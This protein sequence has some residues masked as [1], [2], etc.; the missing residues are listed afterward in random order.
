MT[1][2]LKSTLM[3]VPEF[4]IGEMPDYGKLTRSFELVRIALNTLER[5]IGDVSGFYP[6]NTQWSESPLTNLCL[7][8]H[9]GPISTIQ[10]YCAVDENIEA[11][12]S[13][14]AGRNEWPLHLWPYDTSGGVAYTM[15]ATAYDVDGNLLFQNDVGVG[16]TLEELGDYKYDSGRNMIRSFQ[17]MVSGTARI[18]YT[19]HLGA[20]HKLGIGNFWD[21]A[22]AGLNVMPSFYVP[23]HLCTSIDVSASPDPTYDYLIIMKPEQY[24]EWSP[25]LDQDRTRKAS[26]T[27]P[28]VFDQERGIVR[29]IT[30]TS[31][32]AQ[33]LPSC[34]TS[35]SLGD[36][37]PSSLVALYYSAAHGTGVINAGHYFYKDQTSFYYKKG[38][39]LDPTTETYRVIT[40]AGQDMDTKIEGMAFTLKNHRHRGPQAISHRDLLHQGYS[41]ALSTLPV[42]VQSDSSL[43]WHRPTNQTPNLDNPHPQYLMRNGYDYGLDD[44]NLNNLMLGDLGFSLQTL[45]IKTAKSTNVYGLDA[46]AYGSFGVDFGG[47]ADIRLITYEP[48]HRPPYLSIRTVESLVTRVGTSLGLQVGRFTNGALTGSALAVNVS[49]TSKII[50]VRVTGATS[51][52]VINDCEIDKLYVTG[53]NHYCALTENH[54]GDIS[55][56]GYGGSS[57]YQDNILIQQNGFIAGNSYNE[58]INSTALSNQIVAIHSTVTMNANGSC[59]IGAMAVAGE[60]NILECSNIK[61]D[62]CAI[63]STVTVDGIQNASVE[64]LSTGGTFNFDRYDIAE[65]M[66]YKYAQDGFRFEAQ[67]WLHRK[68]ITPNYAYEMIST[69]LAGPETN[70]F[71]QM[72]SGDSTG[73][74]RIMAIDRRPGRPTVD[75]DLYPSTRFSYIQSLADARNETEVARGLMIDFDLDSDCHIQNVHLCLRIDNTQPADT[76]ITVESYHRWLN[77]YM[78]RVT[79]TRILSTPFYHVNEPAVV[80]FDFSGENFGVPGAKWG[81]NP[82]NPIEPQSRIGASMWVS[83]GG[84]GNIFFYGGI[85]EFYRKRW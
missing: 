33:K 57:V 19:S 53:F 41:L 78:H 31:L 56:L 60:I 38:V 64:I 23:S 44:A 9:I 16:G 43:G 83:S 24:R 84:S 1:D 65:G 22:A 67:N 18:V 3:N 73:A 34:F 74:Y 55:I 58:I 63:T 2:K 37:I 42:S 49:A 8:R 14:L 29:G 11:R 62:V 71:Y 77:G 15:E 6:L 40:S 32:I 61:A 70:A 12:H 52:A 72:I 20:E 66:A 46:G 30:S 68:H 21:G 82:Y 25:P 36:L 4:S 75:G 76:G 47:H 39:T 85:I 28:T 13:L 54:L 50:D 5:Y 26:E 79:S 48:A 81:G 17:R 35:M 7:G 69:E 59:K 10:S 27:Y 51:M 45:D 80:S